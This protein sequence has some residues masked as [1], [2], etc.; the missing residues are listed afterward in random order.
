MRAP[1]IST[2]RHIASVSLKVQP[3]FFFFG[4]GNS[5]TGAL[6]FLAN[7]NSMLYHTLLSHKMLNDTEIERD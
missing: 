2:Q 7:S 3:F 1:K 5:T 4:L 6:T